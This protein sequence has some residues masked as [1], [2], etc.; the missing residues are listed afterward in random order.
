A[1]LD[2]KINPGLVFTKTFKLA[3]IDAAYQAMA[4]RKAIKSYV[5]VE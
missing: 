3:E 5:V 4:E 1:V 2:G